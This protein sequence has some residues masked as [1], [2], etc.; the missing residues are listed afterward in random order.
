M[1]FYPFRAALSDPVI[2]GDRLYRRRRFRHPSSGPP[3]CCC[4]ASL[5]PVPRAERI[6]GRKFFPR[7]EVVNS[8]GTLSIAFARYRSTGEALAVA[9][10]ISDRQ[11]VPPPVYIQYDQH[12][13]S[14]KPPSRIWRLVFFWRS[15]N[16]YVVNRPVLELSM[17]FSFHNSFGYKSVT[18]FDTPRRLGTLRA[19]LGRLA[20]IPSALRRCRSPV[21]P[22]S[23]DLAFFI[24]G[25]LICRISPVRHLFHPAL[26]FACTV[27]PRSPKRSS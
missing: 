5:W 13:V 18:P 6:F 26:R 25:F 14:P 1:H 11:K 17:L 7:R 3:R 21:P 20:S 4:V 9:P 10:K 12:F 22:S 8:L 27:G 23:P 2:P 19:S 16:V 24:T 15:E